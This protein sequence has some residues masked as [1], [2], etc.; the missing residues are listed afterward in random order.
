MFDGVCT[1]YFFTHLL[2]NFFLSLHSDYAALRVGG[3][4]IFRLMSKLVR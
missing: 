3:D 4:L 2:N 1:T